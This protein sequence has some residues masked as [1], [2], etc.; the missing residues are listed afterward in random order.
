MRR[1][2]RVARNADRPFVIVTGPGRS[3]TS[4]VARVL[5]ESGL[6]MG[7]RF[8][9]PSEVN[10]DGFYEDWDVLLLNEQLMRDAGMLQRWQPER[11]PRR[12]TMLAAARRYRGDMTALVAQAGDGWKDPRFSITL[13]AWLPLLPSK[14]KVIVCLRSPEA[15]AESV[16]RVYGL[17]DR[18]AAERQWARHYRRLL[19]VI[20]GYGLEATCLEYDALVERPEETVAALSA[21]VGRPLR[22]EYIDPPLRRHVRPVPERYRRLYERVRALALR[23]GKP[24]VPTHPPREVLEHGGHPQTPG[25]SLSLRAG[26][27]AARL[28]TPQCLAVI[29]NITAHVRAAKNTWET[30]VR[31]PGPALDGGTRAACETYRSAVYEAQQK[32]AALEP[33]PALGR[34]HGLAVREINLQRMIAELTL[35]AMSGDTV[36]KRTMKEAVRAWRRFGRP[37]AFAQAARDRQ[38]ELA[39]ARALEL[40]SPSSSAPARSRPARTDW[41]RP[42]ANRREAGSGRARRGRT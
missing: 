7:Q 18:A 19:D 15:F 33:P 29:D 1:D 3:G 8:V 9:E 39:R 25:P 42:A 23:S 35:A 36:D 37:A 6:R 14:P 30:Q 22:A 41:A 28:G 34:Y 10:P 11:W 26:A 17:V 16:V 5:H 13:E 40:M 27:G 32:L 31:M 4:A 20:R 38:Q 12:A 24:I 2:A 21:F